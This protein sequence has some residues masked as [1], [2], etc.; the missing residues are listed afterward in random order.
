MLNM[1]VDWVTVLLLF[2]A[3]AGGGVARY[4]L[5][6]MVASRLGEEFPWGTIVVN[7][8]GALLI[9]AGAGLIVTGL[10]GSTESRSWQLLALG[11]LGSYT[12]VS[13]FSLQTLALAQQ[14]RVLSALAN[15]L[16]SLALCLS[17]VS[18]GWLAGQRMAGWSG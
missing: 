5:S 10:V 17:L 12:T 8:S 6:G 9:G 7:A 2:F 15:I 11:F 1:A 4:W 18:A 16:L 13:A 3:C 14:G